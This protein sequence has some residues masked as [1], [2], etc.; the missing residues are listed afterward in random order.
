[1]SRMLV[2][3]VLLALSGPAFAQ[4]VVNEILADPAAA[5]GDANCDGVVS[6][7]QDEFVEIV[8]AGAVDVDLSNGTINDGFGLRHVFPAGTVLAPGQAVVVF[9]GGTPTFDGTSP[10]TEAWCQALPGVLLQ[11]ASTGTLGLNNTGDTV[12]VSDANA[13]LLDTYAYGAEGGN[14][15]ALVRQPELDATAVMVEHDTLGFGAWSP[16]TSVDGVA[17]EPVAGAPV[18]TSAMPG[19]AGVSNTWQV[20][21]GD[22][23]ATAIF[24]YS[25]GPAGATPVAACPGLTLGLSSPKKLG[26]DVTNPNG[27]GSVTKTIPASASGRTVRVQVYF[28]GTCTVSNVSVTAFP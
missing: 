9:G 4:T 5:N 7:T 23:S 27:T 11:T 6:P 1:M 19:T 16:G 25:T 28:P 13:V 3:T 20:T 15:N 17:F 21:G 18:V 10:S 2:S 12:T 26:Q 14:D 8:N 24:L 22:A